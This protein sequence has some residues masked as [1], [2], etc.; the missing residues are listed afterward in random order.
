MQNNEDA[1]DKEQMVLWCRLSAVWITAKPSSQHNNNFTNKNHYSD[2][3]CKIWTLFLQS[4]AAYI[5]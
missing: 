5:V 4:V 3:S 2:T 1:A